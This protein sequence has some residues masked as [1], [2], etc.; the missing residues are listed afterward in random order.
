MAE[1]DTSKYFRGVHEVETI[2]PGD[3]EANT[4]A[5][6]SNCRK[7]P[8]HTN[9]IPVKDFS[10]AHLPAECKDDDVFQLIKV[11]SDMT[12]RIKVK[13]VSAERPDFIPGTSDPYPL[14][15]HKGSTTMGTGTGKLD[16][17]TMYREQAKSTL[18]IY[19]PC[20]G[21]VGS[22]KKTNHWGKFEVITAR[23]VVYDDVEAAKT[24]CTFWHDD[25][26]SSTVELKL[27]KIDQPSTNEDWV[28]LY[29]PVC[30]VN[31]LE[32]LK[33]LLARHLDLWQT[34]ND[35]YEKKENNIT[36]IVSHPHGNFKKISIGKWTV[37]KYVEYGNTKYAYTTP[38]CPGSSGAYIYRLGSLLTLHTHSGSNKW[39]NYCGVDCN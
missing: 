20:S 24:T 7:N 6:N 25:K 9:F 12:V 39:G 35:K 33:S 13:C 36:F 5:T 21:C 16:D 32:K 23:H 4:T 10:M 29:I 34:V 2:E 19:C 22:N 17:L 28:R 31:L 27:W 8:G 14:S 26:Q 37:K 11:L 38:T 1:E 18:D 30:D 3:F 15:E